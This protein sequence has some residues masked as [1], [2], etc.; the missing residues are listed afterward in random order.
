MLYHI[1]LYIIVLYIIVYGIIMR[2]I[3]MRGMQGM[4]AGSGTLA[5]YMVLI[6]YVAVWG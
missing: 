5:G 2:G 3:G 1:I 6:V 4:Q